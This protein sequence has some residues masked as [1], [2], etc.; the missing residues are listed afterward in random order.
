MQTKS[1]LLSK[2]FWLQVSAFVSTFVPAVGEFL[3]TNPQ[4]FVGVL[5]A[6]AI[7]V[8]FVTKGKVNILG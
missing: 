7:V 2:T 6:V 8:R 3:R 5:S 1:I 4:E